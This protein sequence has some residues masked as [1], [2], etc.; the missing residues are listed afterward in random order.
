MNQL[1]C[2][3]TGSNGY[4]GKHIVNAL[5]LQGCIVYELGRSKQQAQLENFFLEFSLNHS[6]LPNLQHIDVLIH[7]AYDFSAN[8]INKSKQINLDGTQRLFQHA[9]AS[10]VKR[11]IF[12]SS[13]SAFENAKSVYGKTK[14]AIEVQAKKFGAIIIRPGLIF[15]KKTQGI[16]GAMQQFVKKSPVVPLIS[17]G[18]QKFYLCYIDDLCHLI[19]N[20]IVINKVSDKPIV[21]AS[22]QPITFRQLTKELAKNEN[23]KVILIPIP[24]SLIW[25]G[26]KLLEIL[27]FNIGLRSDSLI[28]AQFYNK[29]PDFSGLEVLKKNY[30]KTIDLKFL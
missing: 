24:F 1:K 12:I 29:N 16:V 11:I 8:T 7:C 3:V 28:G 9:N 25:L 2:A 20:L 13:L 26:L 23:K 19:S 30:F 27:S 22:K 4:V 5:R 17:L 14:L 18:N 6:T 21:A 10:G 15:G